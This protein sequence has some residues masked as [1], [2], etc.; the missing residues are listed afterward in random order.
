MGYFSVQPDH[1]IFVSQ[2]CLHNSGHI[3]GF[4][5]TYRYKEAKLSFSAELLNTVNGKTNGQCPTL[6]YIILCLSGLS[7]LLSSSFCHFLLFLFIVNFIKT[8][9]I[10]A[11]SVQGISSSI[12]YGFLSW[13]AI[14]ME[15]QFG[16][17]AHTKPITSLPMA[18]SS[19]IYLLPSEHC[20]TLPVT[21]QS[22]ML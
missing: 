5:V 11:T 22:S 7:K 18:N 10:K 20:V 8:S 3:Q 1:L 4:F 17:Y 9:Q 15:R 2:V 12:H 14:S 21:P 16:H 6:L 19:N 13:Q